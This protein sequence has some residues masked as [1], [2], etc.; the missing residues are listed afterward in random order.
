M[1]GGW[2][3]KLLLDTHIWLWA[4]R[5]PEKLAKR[6]AAALEDGDNELFLSPISIWEALLLAHKKRV[7]IPIALDDWTEEMLRRLGAKQAEITFEVASEWHRLRTAHRDP[8]D[9]F[10]LA[11]ARV[12]D[13]TF[14][15]ADEKL[16]CCGE[17][18]VLP[19]R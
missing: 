1:G 5:E 14:V 10:L 7:S 11:T 6:V 16:I 17:V 13:L 19:N 8:A 15:T 9:R 18:N 4:N 12:F 2:G 3:L